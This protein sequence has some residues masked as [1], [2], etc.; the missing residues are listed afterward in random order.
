MKAAIGLD[1]G[2]YSIKCVEIA[3]SQ[4]KFKLERVSILLID[5]TRH[6][7]VS[8]TLK[9]MFEHRLHAA[10]HLRV[11]VSGT[12]SILTR[13]IQLP[14]MTH[15]ELK[16]AIRFEAETHIPFPVDDC[17]LDFQIL[18]Q[19]EDKK[20]MNILLVAVKKDLIQERLKILSAVNLTPEVIDVDILCLINAYEILGPES[21]ENTV[22]L[23]NIGHTSSLFTILQDKRPFFVRELPFGALEVTKVLAKTKAISEKE[24]DRLKMEC[25]LQ[26]LMELRDA[27]EKG[28]APLVEEMAHSIDYYENETGEELKSI[29]LSGGGALCTGISETLSAELG[30]QVLLWDSTKK[31]EFC[32]DIDQKFLMKHS[33]EL[34]VAFGMVLRGTGY[35]K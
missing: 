26:D 32:E 29:W 8:K 1:I 23:L 21:K 2:N 28:F 10:R 22:G 3:S 11:S 5:S 7:S 15:A 31:M 14:T 4:D 24:A 16:S 13:R 25:A 20:N 17:L 30:K 9:L 33:A 27:N 12:T 19:S 18:N 35:K 6:D 34:N